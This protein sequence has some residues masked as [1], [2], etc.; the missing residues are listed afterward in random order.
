M[1]TQTHTPETA[2]SRANLYERLNDDVAK[3]LDVIATIYPVT[4][5]VIRKT[6]TETTTVCDLPFGCA[7]DMRIYLGIDLNE[8]YLLFKTD[9]N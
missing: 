8:F 9:E 6:L 4:Y 2:L 7:S 5:R 1:K 3:K